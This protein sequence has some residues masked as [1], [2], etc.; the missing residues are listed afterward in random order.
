MQAI[1]LLVVGMWTG[2]VG[3][4]VILEWSCR[5]GPAARMAAEV[6]YWLD[7]L[8]EAP[9]VAAVTATGA[10]LLLDAWPPGPVLAWKLALGAIP[11]VSCAYSIL[12]VLRRHRRLDDPAALAA[13]RI[14]VL[15]SALAAGP[16]FAAIYLG[17]RLRGLV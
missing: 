7:L 13:G 16:G 17:L 6:H 2:L 12:V 14:R 9:L 1:H 11:I 8:L 15:A 5:E 10:L 3:A 4:E